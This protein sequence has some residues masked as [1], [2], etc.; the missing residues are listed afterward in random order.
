VRT[1][2]THGLKE[3]A[4]LYGV[5]TSYEGMDGQ[6]QRADP[7]ALSLTLQAL[8]ARWAAAAPPATRCAHAGPRSQPSSYSRCRWCGTARYGRSASG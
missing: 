4:R 6:V 8:G 3:L 1:K 7:E 2:T 5:E